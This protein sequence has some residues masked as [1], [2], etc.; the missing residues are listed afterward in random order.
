M[1]QQRKAGGGVRRCVG[2]GRQQ[3]QRGRLGRQQRVRGEGDSGSLVEF[4]LEM[5]ALEYGKG[6]ELEDESHG[7]RL[8]DGEDGGA[9]A[10]R[11]GGGNDDDDNN[12]NSDN[13]RGMLMTSPATERVARR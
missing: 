10:K 7:L 2:R 11:G 1:R 13:R 4:G 5:S 6:E 3:Q 8:F 12:N 9:G